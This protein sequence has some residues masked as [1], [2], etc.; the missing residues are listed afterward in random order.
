MAFE[1]LFKIARNFTDTTV[2]KTGDVLVGRIL[3]DGLGMDE[4][5]ANAVGEFIS[6]GH[7][8]MKW[9]GNG[10]PEEDKTLAGH[11]ASGWQDFKDK[12]AEK[13]CDLYSGNK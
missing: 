8:D 12:T 2:K 9:G 3:G 5:D 4:H 1:K 11:I 6:K 13:M 7:D 10:N